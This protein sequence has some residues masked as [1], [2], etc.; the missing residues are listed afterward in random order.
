MIRWTVKGAE[1]MGS[2]LRVREIAV[3]SRRSFVPCNQRRKAV[4]GNGAG[5]TLERSTQEPRTRERERRVL[6]AGTAPIC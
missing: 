5:Q 4:N 6:D 3:T 1:V 2:V